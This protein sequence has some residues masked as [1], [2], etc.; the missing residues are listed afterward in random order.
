MTQKTHTRRKILVALD[1]SPRSSRTVGY[2]CGFKPF[3]DMD[4]R[5]FHVFSDVPEPYA[6]MNRRPSGQRAA[7]AIQSWQVQYR[8]DITEFM[9]RSRSQ[10]LAAGLP[11]QAVTIDIRNKDKGIARDI[12][13]E[14]GQGYFTL[15]ARRRGFGD[16]PDMTLGS[17]ASKL[18]EKALTVPL[19]LAGTNTAKGSLLVAVDG[20]PGSDRAVQFTADVVG[21]HPCEITLCSIVRGYNTSLEKIDSGARGLQDNALVEEM[22]SFMVLDDARRILERAGV[23]PETVSQQLVTGTDSRAGAIAK[24]A[25]EQCCDTLILGRKGWSNVQDFSIGRVTWKTIHTARKHTVWIVS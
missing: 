23:A 14:A 15:V 2:L 11:A 17:V 19:I 12:I 7:S 8:R 3:H 1:G 9:E 22:E 5:L 18:I 4:I 10:L 21:K 20:S 6:D 25:R 16:L 24:L 13:A